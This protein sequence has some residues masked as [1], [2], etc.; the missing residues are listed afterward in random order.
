VVERGR[1]SRLTNPLTNLLGHTH[2]PPS[3]RN[4]RSRPSWRWTPATSSTS[5]WSPTWPTPRGSRSSLSRLR[6]A[7][8]APAALLPPPRQVGLPARGEIIIIRAPHV[9]GDHTHS[10][11]PSFS[12]ISHARLRTPESLQLRKEPVAAAAAPA[13][14]SE[15]WTPRVGDRVMGPY[16]D[17][18]NGKRYPGECGKKA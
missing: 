2:N 6:L 13:V 15:P 18:D 8:G 14:S 4:H 16:G 10:S 9:V 12:R 7:E 5:S 11:S 3:P 17:K 1:W